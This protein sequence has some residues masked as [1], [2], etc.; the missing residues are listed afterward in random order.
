MDRGDNKQGAEKTPITEGLVGHNVVGGDQRRP[1]TLLRSSLLVLSVV[2]VAYL[3]GLHS[4]PTLL[5]LWPSRTSAAVGGFKEDPAYGWKDDIWPIRPQQPWD[6]S[7][8]FPFPRK[9][10]YDVQEGTWMRLDV[11]SQGDIIFDMLGEFLFSHFG[12]RLTLL[13]PR[14]HL[15]PAFGRTLGKPDRRVNTSQ[16]HPARYPLRL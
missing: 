7:T 11:S 15:L 6:I 2:L 5:K 10:T 4:S 16:S 8:D 3:N 12:S 9:L 13:N 14:G 1:S